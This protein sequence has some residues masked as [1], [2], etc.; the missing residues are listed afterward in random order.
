MS[1]TILKPSPSRGPTQ[2]CHDLS[3]D[4]PSY[5]A[6][7]PP[8]DAFQRLYTIREAAEL[9]GLKYWLLLRAVNSG[10][11]PSYQFSNARRRVRLPD[12]EA[13]IATAG[14]TRGRA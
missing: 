3:K 8:A 10:G 4:Q 13:A 2:H 7:G 11:V 6:G 14:Q 9:T 5:G 1:T 12:I